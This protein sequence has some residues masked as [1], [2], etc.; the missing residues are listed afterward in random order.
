MQN[1]QC[2]DVTESAEWLKHG[3]CL[4][5]IREPSI[6]KYQHA[7]GAVNLTSQTLAQFIADTDPERPILVMC[8]HG[9]S[10]KNAAE[11]IYNQGFKHVYSIDGG[12]NAWRSKYPETL[13]SDSGA[14]IV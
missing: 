4:V 11:F 14:D 13:V 8:Y 1:Y 9:I 10:S 6:F 3:A 7:E 2:I 5:D 12:F